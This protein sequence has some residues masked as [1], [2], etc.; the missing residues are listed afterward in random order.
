MWKRWAW[1]V[2]AGA[3][4]ATGPGLSPGDDKPALPELP[5]PNDTI[6]LQSPGKPEQKVTVIKATRKPDGTVVTEVKDPATGQTFTLED[7]PAGATPEKTPDAKAPKT[8]SK[9]T[10]ASTDTP[11]GKNSLLP[12][13]KD[14]AV[15]PMTP[16]TD[17]SQDKR[18]LGGRLFGK[19]QQNTTDTTQPPTPPADPP[20]RPGILARIFGPKKPPTPPASTA[21]T[22]SAM[23]SSVKSTTTTGPATGVTSNP[24]QLMPQKQPVP[25]PPPMQVDTG[26]PPVIVVPAPLPMTKPAPTTQPV[27]SPVPVP[28]PAPPTG[29][30]IPAIPSPPGGLQSAQPLMPGRPIEVILPVGYVPADYALAKDIRPYATTLKEAPSPTARIIAA[31]GLADGRHGSTDEVKAI[32]FQAA[33]ADPCPEVRACCIDHLCRLGYY[34]PDFI[35]Y[36]KISVNDRSEDVRNAA[37]AGLEKMTPR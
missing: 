6:T 27:P 34:H 8:G 20:K 26:L 21:P 16:T 14:R 9:S 32:L 28:L 23:P 3:A 11:A 36:L 13:A 18:L 37:R 12:R 33:L 15:D 1:G 10:T 7:A 17:T 5:K 24:P 31:Q 30:P 19:D 35:G 2:L 25:P 29:V 4:I 22:T